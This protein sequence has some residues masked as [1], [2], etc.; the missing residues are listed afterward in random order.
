[1]KISTLSEKLENEVINK[2]VDQN[3]DTPSLIYEQ[4]KKTFIDLC[5]IDSFP[6]IMLTKNWAGKIIWIILNIFF[7]GA[8]A[9]LVISSI[10]SYYQYDLVSKIEM[11]NQKPIEFFS[12]N[13]L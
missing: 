4:M 10:L 11:I 3:I 6:K 9:W 1:M 2:P 12:S 13:H 5:H 7:T 8:T